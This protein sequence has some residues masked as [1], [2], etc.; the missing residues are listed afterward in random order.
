MNAWKNDVRF[1]E[2][3][4]LRHCYG[5]MECGEMECGGMECGEM[6]HGESHGESYDEMKRGR[7]KPQDRWRGGYG[8]YDGMSGPTYWQ[9]ST[10]V[11][12]ILR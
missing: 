1:L 6:S 12:R 4:E 5:E 3:R 2:L 9:T 8:S 11:E 10:F 7:T